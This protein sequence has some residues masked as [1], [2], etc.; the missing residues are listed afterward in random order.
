[1]SGKELYPIAAINVGV[2]DENLFQH[3][4]LRGR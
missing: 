4:H 1:M 3:H 2:P